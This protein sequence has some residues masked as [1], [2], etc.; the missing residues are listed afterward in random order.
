MWHAQLCVGERQFPTELYGLQAHSGRPRV[1][2]LVVPGNPGSAGFYRML[3]QQVFAAFDGAADVMAVS[4]VGH[5]PDDI[6]KGAVYG[7][8]CQVQHKAQLCRELTAPGRPPLVILAHS[9]GAYIM[10][11]VGSCA[12]SPAVGLIHSCQCRLAPLPLLEQ[13]YRSKSTQ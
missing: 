9:I 2:V 10:L 8:D 12:L 13:G 5:D 11:Q 6:S 4:H 1:Q 3:M 7:L